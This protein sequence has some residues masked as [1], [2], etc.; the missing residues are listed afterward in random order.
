MKLLLL[1]SISFLLFSSCEKEEKELT[2]LEGTTWKYREYDE[3]SGWTY[4]EL[5]FTAT[6]ATYTV[7]GDDGLGSTFT[8]T[9]TFDP[10]AVEIV[11]NEWTFWNSES[12]RTFETRE[13]HHEGTVSGKNMVIM[14]CSWMGDIRMGI[15]FK[16]VR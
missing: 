5:T 14:M 3:E 4:D 11:S 10:P 8:G 2:T 13:L 12:E 15:K 1:T 7:T 16:R 9:Y 6:H